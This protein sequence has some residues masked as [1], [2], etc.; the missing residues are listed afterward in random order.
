MRRLSIVID[1]RLG[2]AF[3]SAR[4]GQGAGLSQRT[5]HH[6]RSLGSGGSFRL[7]RESDRQSSSQVYRPADRGCEQTRSRRRRGHGIPGPLQTRRV[8]DVSGLHRLQH[9]DAGF[10][11]Q[12]PFQVRRDHFYLPHPDQPGGPGG[13]GGCALAHLEGVHCRREERP[14]QVHPRE[15]RDRVDAECRGDQVP[16]SDRGGSQEE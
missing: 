12:D 7:G 11:A 15:L 8:H 10:H 16:E 4:S 2:G 5:H 3:D 1:F 13:E 9:P 6:D 14:G